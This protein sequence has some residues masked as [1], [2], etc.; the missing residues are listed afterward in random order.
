[1]VLLFPECHMCACML[2]HFSCV[3]LFAT[4]WI[5]AHLLCSWGFSRQEYWSGLPCPPPGD[6]PDPGIKPTSLMSP[7]LAGRF[8]T[9]SATWEVQNVIYLDSYS[10]SPFHI[11]F[12][13]LEV[14]I[15]VSSLSFR[16]LIS[17]YYWIIFCFLNVPQF[18][19]I[20]SPTEGHLG[21]FQVL[22]TCY[23]HL[24]AGFCMET[25]FKFLWI[26]TKKHN[27]C[28]IW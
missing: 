1:M 2:S 26:N 4:L 20:H 15:Q 16:G 27:C 11:T 19:I 9:I 8:F 25:S 23:K 10:T 12:F 18:I 13:P 17:F 7:T 6:L 5:V 22:A 28:I 21:Y 24:C 3:W 14:C